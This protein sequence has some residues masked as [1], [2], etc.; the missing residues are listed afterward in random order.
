MVG[1]LLAKAINHVLPAPICLPCVHCIFAGSKIRSG[2]SEEGG[3]PLLVE[4]HGRQRSCPSNQ[5]VAAVSVL[6]PGLRVRMG[7]ASG[8]I[9][10]NERDALSSH[11]LD[12]ARG[13]W[14]VLRCALCC[15]MLFFAKC[16]SASMHTLCKCCFCCATM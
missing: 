16:C 12:I 5:V 13:E 4:Q 11:V 8:V 10:H 3:G 6:V 7:V 14:H 9:R 15:A 2:S 1:P